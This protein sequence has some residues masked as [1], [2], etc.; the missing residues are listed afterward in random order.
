M[1][2]EITNR[3]YLFWTNADFT[4]YL[5][6]NVRFWG[7]NLLKKNCQLDSITTLS[8]G[9]AESFAEIAIHLTSVE[10]LIHWYKFPSTSSTLEIS[11]L[12]SHLQQSWCRREVNYWYSVLLLWRQRISPKILGNTVWFPDLGLIEKK[13]TMDYWWGK[14]KWKSC[15]TCFIPV[16]YRTKHLC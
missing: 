11:R 2:V 12:W 14:I 13:R 3:I 16:S 10:N 8:L 6:Q 4:L 9:L 15:T 1:T 5:I 7:K